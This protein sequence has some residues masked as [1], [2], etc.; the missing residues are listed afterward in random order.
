MKI[1][2]HKRLRKALGKTKDLLLNALIYDRKLA[3][4]K[5]K[6]IELRPMLENLPAIASN[7][8]S[9]YEIHMVCGKRDL[10]MGIWSSWSIMRYMDGKGK[11]YVHSD[12]TIDAD[13]EK[14]WRKKVSNLEIVGR[15]NAEK[16]ASNLLKETCPDLYEWRSSWGSF[17]TSQVIDSHLFGDAKQILI[18]DSDVLCFNKPD[19]ILTSLSYTEPNFRWCRDLLDAYLADS[20]FLT[21][22]FGFTVPKALNCG[23]IT[24]PRFTIEDYQF[25]DNAIGKLRK[26]GIETDRFWAAQTIYGIMAG[27]C[28]NSSELPQTYSNTN[29]RI[30][31]DTKVRHFVGVPRIRHR[32]FNEG[33]P[34]L[35]NS[36]KPD[37]F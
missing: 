37:L 9:L 27:R 20:T 32:F 36:V 21:N 29:E 31:D 19:E 34:S 30:F 2:P 26:S 28:H 14:K 23:F 22:L 25:I 13:S 18:M 24:C 3:L 16:A 35:L 5:A 11:L 12:G 7:E 15:D 17:S 33:V 6:R 1:G 10:D 8:E 4:S